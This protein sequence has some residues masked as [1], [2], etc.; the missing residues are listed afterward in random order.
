MTAVDG[1][2]VSLARKALIEARLRRPGRP[3]GS[4]R[5]PR[6]TNPGDAPLSAAQLQLWYLNQLAP[7]STAYNELITVRKDGPFDATAF[8]W[9]FNEVIRRHEA[10]RTTFVM[11]GDEPCQVVHEHEPIDLP[12][13]DLGHLPYAEAENTAAR[14]AAE[15]TSQPYDLAGGPLLRPVLV[16]FSATHH[17]LY[18]ALHH[19]IF[20]GVT[21]YQIVLPELVALYDAHRAGVALEL[22]EPPIQ[23]SDYAV[24]EREWVHGPEAGRRLDRC[25]ARL[26]GTAPLHLP[27][28]HPRP[29]RQRFRGS[30]VPLTIDATTGQSLRQIAAD[31]G[32]TLFQ[33]LATVYAYW[34]RSYTEQDD[35]V[36]ATAHDLRQ[37]PHLQSMVGY[38]L[39]PVV[40][41][42]NVPEHSTCLDLLARMRTEVL[43]ALG[44]AM[45]FEHLVR[46]I[47]PPRD[48]RRNPLFQT[49]FVLEPPMVDTDPA[50]SIHQ[51]E[52]AVGEL[53]GQSKFDVS[54][55]LDERG[56]GQICGRLIYDT[57]LFDAGTAQLMQ[58]H[59]ARLVRN[60][61]TAPDLALSELSR[62]DAQDLRRQL[63]EF[64]PPPLPVPDAAHERC[65]HTLVVD[66][67]T[68][69]PDAV[70]VVV[71]D[72]HLT[73]ADLLAASQQVAARLAEA[74]AGPGVVVATSLDRSIQLVPALLGVLLS[75]SAYLPLDL[76]QPESRSRFMIA[77]AGATVL[78]TDSINRT[79]FGAAELAVVD[80]ARDAPQCRDDLVARFSATDSDPHDL[81]CVIYTSGSTGTPKGVELEHRNLVNL[82]L[83]WP[84][85][86][87]L[88][89]ADTV[90]SVA[91]Y[92]FDV[93]VGDIF[94]ALTTGATVVLAT[95]AQTKDPL[96]LAALIERCGASI[97][98]ATPTTWSMLVG[99]GWT[100]RPG[101]V[102]ASVGEPLPDG[103]ARE[104]GQRCRA[105]WNGW[106]PTETT[107]Y[108][109]GGFV[110]PGEPVTVGRP[111]PGVRI[112]VLDKAA[113]PL[114]CG[115]PGEIYVAGNG[116]SRG[117]VNRP[118][119]SAQ[120]YRP[121]PFFTGERMYRTGDRGR[122]LADGRLQHLG[123]YDN[124]AKVRGYRI[125]L[126]EV[127][128]VLAGHPGIAEVAVAAHDDG[129]GG[130]QLVAYLVGTDDG[131]GDADVRRWARG[132]L[133][134][135]MIP[136]LIVHLP[137]LPMSVSG[138]LDRAALP[139]PPPPRQ[140]TPITAAEAQPTTSDQ[141][142][143]S[144]IWVELL[145]A[146]VDCDRSVLDPRRD[147]F[148]LGGHSV[149]ATRLLVEVARRLGI[150]IPVADFLEHGT[151]LAGLTALVD[152]IRV[153]G[154]LTTE[155]PGGGDSLFFVYP[156][157]ASSMSLRH[158][159]SVWEREHRV[160]PLITPPLAGR[161]GGARTIEELAEL[162]LQTIRTAQPFG[163]Y[164]L[165]G[166]SFGGLLAY[167][168][169]R[170]LHAEGEHVAWLGLLDTPTPEVF[171]RMLRR[172]KSLSGRL[173]RLRE[174][175]RSQLVTEYA[176]NLWWSAREKLA[177]AGLTGRRPGEQFDIRHAWQIMLDCTSQ[178]HGVPMNLFVTSDTVVQAGSATL[179]WAYHHRGPVQVHRAPGDHDSLLSEPLT[180][181]FTTLVSASL[182]DRSTDIQ[183]DTTVEERTP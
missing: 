31:H 25:R 88:S 90:V 70:A 23:Y 177:A 95:D 138:K 156:D 107:V 140:P 48:Q 69:T 102:A 33:L 158:L 35:V 171:R 139:A 159:S 52:T 141:R 125:E 121:D 47:D 21:L 166:Y 152:E 45:P 151:T 54:V 164:R 27:L 89:D 173:A 85:A 16:R 132:R 18:L 81:A 4:S 106:G 145:P 172:W 150:S 29:A 137:A 34:L 120:R 92:T 46:A 94:T 178:G 165:I 113:R 126:G 39:T 117:Y 43:D 71:G 73:Y 91:S 76:N 110:E 142:H 32:A 103:L 114:P 50:W 122:L 41:R 55:E 116:V 38:C 87:G 135:Y 61:A 111:L 108:A 149:L 118:E 97:M 115:V 11:I 1:D 119:E 153:C 143:L 128:A 96:E 24:W 74:G 78:L 167:E 181:Q 136:G 105:V 5:I 53:V 161:T 160:H 98:A 101:L 148:E 180:R 7:D 36:F 86:I 6:R 19:L 17:R 179:G 83:A 157:L 174:S 104:L 170:L 58:S 127:E 155:P 3:A 22:P 28:D 100:G 10:W 147:F 63:D 9:A 15:N 14:I 72:Q 60:V 109:G 68:R 84:H 67:A 40:L 175:Q 42:I 169:A 13:L 133:P 8:T 144:D 134:G 49:A 51:M 146:A 62:P 130:R 123:R 80:L 65:I 131:I 57:D 37:S 75:G 66:Q 2:R 12:V 176:A 163:P 82:I 129:T 20:D 162:L 26:A 59:F 93:S 99:A 168:V 64:N 154:P 183:I 79:Q 56:D 44:C 112:Y 30:M 182:R 124:Q 77:D